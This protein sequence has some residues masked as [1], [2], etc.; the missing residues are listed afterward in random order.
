MKRIISS[1]FL[2]VLLS[3]C[4]VGIVEREMLTPGASILPTPTVVSPP[5]DTPQPT[6][7][8]ALPTI[9]SRP[10]PT[11]TPFPPLINARVVSVATS[12]KAHNVELVSHVDIEFVAD[13]AVAGG[14]AYVADQNVGLQVVDVSAVMPQAVSGFKIKSGQRLLLPAKALV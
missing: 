6:I 10:L 13:V 8:L 3:A 2:C 1:L 14:F 7:T 4:T 9:T 5:V 11:P 12:V